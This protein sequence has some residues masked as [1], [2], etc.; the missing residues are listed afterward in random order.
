MIARVRPL[1]VLFVGLLL[2]LAGCDTRPQGEGPGH[3]PQELALSPE[4]ELELGRKAYREVLGQSKAL[5]LNSKEVKRVTHVGERIAGTMKIEPL[6]R[7]INLDVKDY[8]FEWQFNV[9]EDKQVNAFCLPGGKVAVFTGLLHVAENDDQ[10]AA[11]LGHEVAHA[12]AHHAS[13]RL[14]RQ[15]REG[16]G[17]LA[18]LREKH[19]DREQESEADH[20]GLFLMTFAGYDPGQ[21]VAFWQ[22]MKQLSDER[23]QVPEI[24]SDHPSDEKR[25]RQLE[26]W[27]PKA[28]AAKKAYDEGRIEP[29]RGR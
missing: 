2:P 11:V 25:I 18:A 26:E 10:L 16:G 17:L 15:E 29:P 12:L 3:R 14:A 22:R 1:V 28:K 8:R 21:A 7:E 9:L 20:I 19:Y 27:V 4:Q 13:E 5:P 6:M 24:L 23:G